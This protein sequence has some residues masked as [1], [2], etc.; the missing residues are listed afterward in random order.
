[1]KLTFDFSELS[2][3][4]GQMG[5]ELID[6]SSSVQLN[7]LDPIDSLLGEGFEVPFED[8]E[9]ETGLASYEGR[10]VLLYIKDHS[11]NNKIYAVLR[12]GTQGNK[13]H[14]ADCEMLD[15]MRK[16]GRLER[17]VVTNKLNGIFEISGSDNSNKLIEGEV[18]LN[19]CQYCLDVL[20]YKNFSSVPRGPRRK[21]FVATFALAEFFDT[22]SSYF[23]FMPLGIANNRNTGYAD[24][25]PGISRK[26]RQ[27]FYYK[28]QQ[29]NL[30]LISHK[31]LLHV[32]HINGVKS[33]NSDSNL[34]PLCADCHRK[35]P[36]HRHM[37]V[38]H[39]ETKLI[40]HLRREQGLM[41]KDKWQDIYDLAD[42]GMHGVINLLEKY[43]VS[44]PE[45]GEEIQNN[46]HEVVT[47]LEL[48]WPLKKVGVAID[49]ASAI[50]AGKEG[51]KVFSMR[52]AL[53]QLEDLA[54]RLR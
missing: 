39:E 50:V 16:K 10:Q 35:Q 48:A 18:K 3:A 15:R 43:K 40:T 24:N 12:D 7:V 46:S 19:V 44:L 37:F 38:K 47:E 51:W 9:F 13:F 53:S 30:D 45:V 33:D 2:R 1:M 5:A 27:N 41:V 29:C 20:N 22:Y 26:V 32:H 52:L 49:K 6:F 14:I 23:K 4:V 28:C 42:P 25:W 36:N 8:I 54:G 34:T 11:Y 17:Y 31:N 21:E